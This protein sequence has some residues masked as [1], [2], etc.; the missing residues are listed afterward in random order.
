MT[1]KL[2]QALIA[3]NTK[4]ALAFIDSGIPIDAPD[5]V[6]RT[7]LMLAV[8][9]SFNGVAK[10]LL[11]RGARIHLK[12]NNGKTALDIAL[13]SDNQEGRNMLFRQLKKGEL[14]AA[15]FHAARE[16]DVDALAFLVD[17]MGV[18]LQGKSSRG[19]TALEEAEVCTQFDAAAWIEDKLAKFPDEAAQQMHKGARDS[20]RAMKKLTLKVSP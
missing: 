20:F 9:Q 5:D 15:M 7:A 18:S 2:H 1:T 16:G 3:G 6:G 14:Q 13:G 8:A 11:E 12:E 17:E 4:A 10:K 19:K